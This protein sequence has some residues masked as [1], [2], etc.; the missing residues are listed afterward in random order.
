MI[1][2]AMIFAVFASSVLANAPTDSLRP[3][4]SAKT[5]RADVAVVTRP[6]PAVVRDAPAAVVEPPSILA[7]SLSLRPTLRPLEIEQ[8]AA[9]KRRAQRRGAICGDVNIQGD[10][11]GF[12]PGRINGCGVQGAVKVRAVSGIGLT[13]EAVMTCTTA[14][15][16]KTWVDRSAKPALR[17][18]NGGL[19]RLK[20][21]AH[22]AC[23]TRNNLPGAKISE[24]GKGKAID[25]SGFHMNDGSLVT[26]LN[27][28]NARST[29]PALKKMHKGACGPFGTVLG[30][31]SDR[32][33]RDHF[34]FDTAKHRGGAFCR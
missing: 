29:G 8:K 9:A 11:V 28:W 32:F 16:L 19:D 6:E 7:A 34:H 4:T 26:V 20:V 13:Q 2:T 27:G 1:R 22:Y 18:I 24:H 21:A 3:V 12:V 10:E 31:N 30:P 5:P 33:H 14:K 17:N 25:I 15:A 23:R